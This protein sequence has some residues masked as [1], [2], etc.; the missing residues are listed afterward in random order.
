MGRECVVA[1]TKGCLDFGPWERIFYYE[2]D[3]RRN[4]RVLIK[5]IGE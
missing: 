3:G 2:F 4:K 1:V 5:I